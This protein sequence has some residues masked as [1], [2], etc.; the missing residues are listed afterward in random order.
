MKTCLKLE[1]CLEGQKMKQ[2]RVHKKSIAKRDV[3]EFLAMKQA[4]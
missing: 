2:M 3:S 1:R 4:G